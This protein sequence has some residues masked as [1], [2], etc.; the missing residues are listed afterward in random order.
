MPRIRP[1]LLPA[2]SSPGRGAITVTTRAWLPPVVG[3]DE[4]PTLT[5]TCF[6]HDPLSGVCTWTVSVAG[7]ACSA[8]AG[9]TASKPEAAQKGL[10]VT[11]ATSGRAPPT[12]PRAST[13]LPCSTSTPSM[14]AQPSAVV[15]TTQPA[16]LNAAPAPTVAPA[17]G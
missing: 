5:L 8:P 15:S 7:P 10:P 16:T 11:D 17:D 6:V 14:P 2:I 4:A 1:L 3:P 13:V 9:T 12:L